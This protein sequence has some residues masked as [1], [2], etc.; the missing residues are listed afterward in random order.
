MD[1]C[2]VNGNYNLNDEGSKHTYADYWLLCLRFSFREGTQK[3]N[4]GLW[5]NEK[6]IW[7]MNYVCLM[8]VNTVTSFGF[9]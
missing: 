4:K 7:N 1:W 3:E 8:I 9:T 5:G 2:L 6:D